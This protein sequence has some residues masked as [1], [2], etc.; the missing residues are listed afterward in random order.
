MSWAVGPTGCAFNAPEENS[1]STAANSGSAWSKLGGFFA[2]I[3]D[4]TITGTLPS[5]GS[6]I[7]RH[8]DVREQP[9]PNAPDPAPAHKVSDRSCQVR[10]RRRLFLGHLQH[11]LLPDSF[12]EF[13]SIVLLHGASSRMR[14]LGVL[15][16]KRI[17]GRPEPYLLFQ[18]N[19]EP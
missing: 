11:R 5:V 15:M 13:L 3:G 1:W 4:R 2:A 9:S 8:L 14:S 19:S 16:A 17:I 7:F 10:Q 12:I 18:I 6:G